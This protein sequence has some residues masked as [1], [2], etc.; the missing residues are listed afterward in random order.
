[1]TSGPLS[2]RPDRPQLRAG[3][4]RDR[5]CGDRHRDRSRHPRDES[6]GTRGR[7][8]VLC[9]PGQGRTEDP[10]LVALISCA[11]ANPTS[12]QVSKKER[13]TCAPS[14]SRISASAA[15]ATSCARRCPRCGDRVT[16][17]AALGWLDSYRRA[18]DIVSPVSGEVIE[19]DAA[20]GRKSRAHQRLSVFAR[21]PR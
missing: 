3:L 1:M 21:R 10:H 5:G 6:Q 17:G 13:R 16:A 4:R 18:F 12:G 19:V 2:A 7:D 14:A 20:R 8:A 11:S 15:W 9:A